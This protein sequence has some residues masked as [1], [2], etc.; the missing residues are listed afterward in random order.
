MQDFAGACG[1]HM[2]C[3]I[4]AIRPEALPTDP[5]V[6][7]EMVLALREREAARGD[8]DAQGHDLREA[9]GAAR[10]GRRRAVRAWARRPRGRHNAAAGQRRPA[11]R[12][13]IRRNWQTAQE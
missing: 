13:A 7:T 11:G 3:L 10:G 6:L 1:A 4:M 5:A 8:A 12:H 9:V 2:Y